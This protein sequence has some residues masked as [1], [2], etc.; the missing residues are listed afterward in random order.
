MRN[1]KSRDEF[2]GEE[3]LGKG[4]CDSLVKEKEESRKR[5]LGEDKKS[6][7]NSVTLHYNT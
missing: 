7:I 3:T 5:A 6:I 2:I 1:G 4:R